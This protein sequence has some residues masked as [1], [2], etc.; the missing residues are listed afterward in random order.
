[1]RAAA[2]RP[3]RDPD[4]AQRQSVSLYRLPQDPRRRAGGRRRRM[5]IP[6]THPSLIGAAVPRPDALAK[7]TGEATYPADLL[8]PD[9]LQL[10][11]VYAGRPHARIVHIETAAALGQPGVVAVL[12]AADVPHNAY[13]LVE[14]DQPVLCGDVVR[15]T[16]DKVA[17]VVAETKEGAAA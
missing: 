10:H 6:S 13:G 2:S 3:R 14:A 9:M 5:T 17:L 1:R 4:G 11:V 15:F 16:G 8:G 7:V 12:T